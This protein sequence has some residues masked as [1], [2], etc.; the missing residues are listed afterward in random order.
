MFKRKF[1]KEKGITL[2]ALVITIIVFLIL[3]EVSIAMLTGETG[4][5]TQAQKAKNETEEARME[6]EN[7]ISD[8]EDYINS[9]TND[10]AIVGKIVTGGNKQY[11]NHGTAIIPEGFM[12]VPGL[13]NIEEGLVISDNASDTEKDGETIVAE[14]NQFV[15]IPVTREEEYIRNIDY[16]FTVLST[17]AYTDNGYLPEEIQPIIPSNITDV[18]EIR[19]NK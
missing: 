17:E 7:R 3:A 4:V 14:G 9:E 6:E 16:E 10:T 11:S 5:L 2:I 12:I 18:K 1:R 15:W 8:Y 19:T 13:D